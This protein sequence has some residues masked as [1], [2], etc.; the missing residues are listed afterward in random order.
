MR[1]RHYVPSGRMGALAMPA[2]L[3]AGAGIAIAGGFVYQKLIDVIPFIYINA[4][5]TI[6]FAF[7]L[8][9]VV[10]FAVGWGKC[11]N[12][13][14]AGA[15][16]LVAGVIAIGFTFH[17]AHGWHTSEWADELQGL[18]SREAGVDPAAA[19]AE[20]EAVRTMSLGDYIDTRV[21]MGW[22]V[23]R[24]ELTG[25]MVW[26]LWL[27][28]AGILAGGAALIAAGGATA[29]FCEP[30]DLY[31]EQQKLG[32]IR[33]LPPP[34]MRTAARQGIPGLLELE[35]GGGNGRLVF[36]LQ[37]CPRCDRTK[38]VTATAHWIKRG[39]DG[40]S[41]EKADLLENVIPTK[42][43]LESLAERFPPR[44]SR[45]RSG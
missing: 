21:E 20:V 14:V 16:G 28:E 10:A 39:E 4:V 18:L 24:I 43:E 19:E 2:A 13:L 34:S 41:E 26:L 22:T 30:C 45:R 35:E 31:T 32:T 12:V 29:P 25:I 44:T 8:G 38:F 36:T 1:E 17:L 42:D 9:L 37:A 15:M 40:N 3:V 27:I 7:L 5:L 11:R 6:G 23:L 33:A